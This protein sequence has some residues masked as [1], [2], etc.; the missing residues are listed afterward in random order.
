MS[1]SVPFAALDADYRE[2]K[3]LIDA[4]MARVLARG[5]FILGEEV[6]AFEAAFAGFLG[7]GPR[8]RRLV[9]ARVA[10][11]VGVPVEEFD[12][13]VLADQV[14]PIPTLVLHDRT[15]R[16]T[17]YAE[18]VELVRGLPEA[19]MITT[20]GLGRQRLL[21]DP[22]VIDAV[23]WFVDGSELTSRLSATA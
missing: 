4:A 19:S 22:Q 8:T 9:D 5:W 7:I 23:S 12:V 1:A 2:K 13:A 17:S 18:S 20:H 21:R 15:D 10:H 3:D 14:G 11:R 6:A 16:Q